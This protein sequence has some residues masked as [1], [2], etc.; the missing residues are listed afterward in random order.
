MTRIAYL[1]SEYP[2]PSH[3]FI[4][5]EIAALRR[6]GV[7][8]VPFSIRPT[9]QTLTT[10]LE[11]A[12]RDETQ[13]VLGRSPLSYVAAILGAFLRRPGRTWSTLRLALR[14]RA[15]GAK[16]MLWTLFYF[17]E[18][19]FLT[20][21][22]R[23]AGA[24]RLHNHF[25]QG[26]A[27]VGMLAAHFNDIP[28]SLTL[29]G[30]SETD[31]PAGLLLGEKIAR[32]DFVACASWF[33][34]AQGMR[35]AQPAHW[36][37]LHVVR[38][39]VD[40]AALPQPQS[41]GDEPV[42]FICVARLSPEKWHRG[43][44]E[45]FAVVRKKT[46]GARLIIVG[47]GPLRPELEELVAALGVQEAVIFH[48]ALDEA[49]TLVAVAGADV[50]VLPSLLEGLPVSLMEAM[51]LG[52]PVISSNVAGIPELVR[53][54]RNGLLFPPSE[55]GALAQHMI[56]LATDR[57]LRERLGAAGKITV[58]EEF[59]IDTAVKPLFALLAR[60]RPSNGRNSESVR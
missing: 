45:A 23:Q 22:L 17:V 27:T 30:V 25:G 49:A 13:A 59:A 7:D 9:L 48:G 16:G 28:W 51:A 12:A 47:D 31:Y 44:L 15:P 54:G 34:R 39:G 41:G 40:L 29:H 57:P 10:E 42:R 35:V 20:G 24:T 36:G 2:K 26:G 58:A 11:R 3:T 33:M 43:L 46:P 38:C 53:D 18:A 4:R 19:I 60:G 21:L 5:R 1:I 32:A 50:L 8:I 56:T 37:K 55:S 6:V 52:K 14:H